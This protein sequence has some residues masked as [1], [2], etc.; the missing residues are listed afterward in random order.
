[1]KE[2][3]V[4]TILKGL[5]EQNIKPHMAFLILNMHTDLEFHRGKALVDKGYDVTEVYDTI[6]ILVAK[7]DLTRFGKKTK[8][9]PKG[10]KV[11]KFVDEVVGIAEKMILR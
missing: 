3:K 8:I 10:L 5:W 7:G 4:Y 1:M 2:D 6:E 11:L 9:T